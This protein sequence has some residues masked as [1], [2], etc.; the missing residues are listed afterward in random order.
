MSGYDVEHGVDF[1][2][3]SKAPKSRRPDLSSFHALRNETY[4]DEPATNPHAQPNPGQLTA[5]TRMAA[6][7]FEQLLQD[8]NGENTFLQGLIDQLDV[9]AQ[10]PVGQKGMPESFFADLE[11][12]DKKKL[13]KEEACPICTNEFLSGRIFS[14]SGCNGM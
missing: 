11:R 6:D 10:N 2:R 5:L 9:D 12:I 13:K 7:F 14:F 1:S 8:A 3:E 4:G